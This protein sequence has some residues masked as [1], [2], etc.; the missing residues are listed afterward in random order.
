MKKSFGKKAL[1][2]TLASAML[3]GN[4][5]VAMASENTVDAYT[6]GQAVIT[7]ASTVSAA[8]DS[9]F[10]TS[11]TVIND[12]TVH[13]S[14]SGYGKKA[15]LLVNGV[16]HESVT[17]SSYDGSWNLSNYF[18]GKAGASYKFTLVSYGSDGSKVTK[19]L[20]TKK[21]KVPSFGKRQSDKIANTDM[22]YI[23]TGYLKYNGIRVYARFAEEVYSGLSYRLLRSTKE[24]GTYSVVSSGNL[25]NSYK[26][27]LTCVDTTAKLNC[28]YYYKI[29]VVTGTDSY[30]KTSKVVATTSAI[31][32]DVAMG[33][34]VFIS[35]TSGLKGV[36]ITIDNRQAG[37]N[38]FD[39]YRSTSKTKGFKKI[40]TL[41]TGFEYTDTTAKAGVVYYYKVIPKYYDTRNGSL[42]SGPATN[43]QAVKLE[44]GWTEVEASQISATAAKL[45]WNKVRGANVY[46][47][48]MRNASISGD[49]FRKVATTK[50]LSVVLRGLEAGKYEF[51]LKSQNRTN[52]NVI[53]ETQ[54]HASLNMGF[55]QRVENVKVLWRTST[56]N[57]AKTSMA[58]TTAIS[59]RKVWGATGYKVMAYNRYTGKNECV[60]TLKSASTVTYKFR[61]PGSTTKGIKYT[62]AYIVPYKGSTLGD[63]SDDIYVNV[64][65]M[66]K[67]VKAA[68]LSN[69]QAKV[70]WSAVAGADSYMVYRNIINGNNAYGVTGVSYVD[71]NCSTSTTYVYTVRAM[72][73]MAGMQNWGDATDSEIGRTG[74]ASYVHKVGTPKIATAENT[75]AGTATLT[76]KKISLAKYYIVYRSTQKDGTY[77]KIGSTVKLTY[78]DKKAVKGKTYYYKV[79]AV[80][81]GDNGVVSTSS[82][83][84]AAYVKSTK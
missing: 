50:E 4:M 57:S 60:A 59:W 40:K 6:D 27:D 32:A 62:R 83:S 79:K 16:V 67:N 28:V 44:L 30:I 9:T 49:S 23:S 78:A 10:I 11:G 66:A 14:A 43:V 26:H 12:G 47:V 54:N 33:R 5:S 39:I 77:S 2:I 1:C 22:S 41:T 82:F 36:D 25:S 74:S 63:N 42:I 21:I 46:E 64:M 81:M 19:E 3:F 15:E 18:Y 70:T 84:P 38:Q 31:K 65:P 80:A 8:I 24:N 34:S 55:T 20:G 29:Q 71:S 69:S 75:A 68:R 37:N 61:N 48:W 51:T 17:G 35:A 52:G 72:S 53:C 56:V 13:V 7:A 45:S 58:V 76:W 73:N